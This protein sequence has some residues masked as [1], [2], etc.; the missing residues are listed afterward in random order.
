MPVAVARA[1]LLQER[2]DHELI[3]RTK[4]PVALVA[5]DRVHLMS[6]ARR[7]EGPPGFHLDVEMRHG[8]DNTNPI[9]WL[10]R[11]G[12]LISGLPTSPAQRCAAS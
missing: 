12:K 5:A 8:M 1:Q 7:H 2:E 6:D 11:A 3:S 9:G 4:T 10:T